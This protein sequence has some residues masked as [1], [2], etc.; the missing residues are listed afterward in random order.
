MNEVPIDLISQTSALPDAQP[1]RPSTWHQRGGFVTISEP[2]PTS[3]SI[4]ARADTGVHSMG[5]DRWLMN[6]PIVGVTYRVFHCP[7]TPLCW[8]P[9]SPPAHPPPPRPPPLTATDPCM[10]CVPL[11][12]PECH[13]A[14]LLQRVSSLFRLASLAYSSAFEVPLLCLFRAGEL[15]SFSPWIS[16][17]WRDVPQFVSSPPL[18]PVSAASGFGC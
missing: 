13:G 10:V 4:R 12:F 7:K 17:P 6:A 9:S 14:G 15:I 18:K 11:P 16:P 3:L 1:P 5:W 8:A 2:T